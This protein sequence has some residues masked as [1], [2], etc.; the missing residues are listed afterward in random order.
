MKSVIRILITVA[1]V[2]VF[3]L[4]GL[5]AQTV[6]PD[7]SLDYSYPIQLPPGTGG[8]APN[9]S[10]DYNSEDENGILGMGFSLGGLS[11]ITRDKSYDITFD[12][13]TDHFLFDG[14]R[15]ISGADGY[16]HTEK[17]SFIRIEFVN[18]NATDSHLVVTM[19]NRTKL[20]FGSTSDSRINAVGIS[21]KARV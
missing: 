5:S 12:D 17:E 18:P 7:G 2:S 4:C 13:T 6:N 20:Y 14:Q 10:I 19:K 11:K 15:L 16:Y 21:G 3:G 8:M 1:L 9:L